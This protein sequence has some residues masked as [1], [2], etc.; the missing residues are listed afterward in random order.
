MRGM[1]RFLAALCLSVCA[2]PGQ[3]TPTQADEIARAKRLLQATNWIDKAWGLIW[4]FP[5][6]MTASAIC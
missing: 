4:R 1:P 2:C 5:S 3:L 6:M